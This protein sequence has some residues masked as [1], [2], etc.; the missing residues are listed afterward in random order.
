M[1]SSSSRNGFSDAEVAV[2]ANRP[3]TPVT[4]PSRDRQVPERW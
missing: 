1:L 3:R 4:A 2:R